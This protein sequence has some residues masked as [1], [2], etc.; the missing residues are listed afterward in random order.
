MTTLKKIGLVVLLVGIICLVS[1]I[2]MF[3]YADTTYSL[4]MIFISI[5]VNI[6]GLNLLIHKKS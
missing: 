3:I 5:I 4:W 2:L 1:G 6:I